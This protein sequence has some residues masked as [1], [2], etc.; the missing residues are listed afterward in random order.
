MFKI[1]KSKNRQLRTLLIKF[2]FL[3]KE[4]DKILYQQLKSK[5]YNNKIWFLS[6]HKLKFWQLSINIKWNVAKF[7]NQFLFKLK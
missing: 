7:I 6:T 4:Y 3:C 5:F 1:I 2:W